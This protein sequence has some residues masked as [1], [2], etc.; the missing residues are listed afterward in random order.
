MPQGINAR[1]VGFLVQIKMAK[2]VVT[3]KIMPNSTDTNLKN[4]EDNSIK[5]I[6]DFGGEVGKVEIEPIAFGLRALKLFFVLNENN[7]NLDS[8]ESDIM[9]IDGVRSVEIID[10]RRAIG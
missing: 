6:R 4:L 2:V 1:N 8:L 7:V 3:L 5:K 9:K 10:A